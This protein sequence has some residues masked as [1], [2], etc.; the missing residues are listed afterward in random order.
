MGFDFR[1]FYLEILYASHVVDYW[2]V[3]KRKQ[4]FSL[5]SVHLANSCFR[6]FSYNDLTGPLPEFLAQLLN[7][8][9]LYVVEL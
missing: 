7:L 6:D 9:T 3:K 8:N 5:T 1:N 2:V 4:L